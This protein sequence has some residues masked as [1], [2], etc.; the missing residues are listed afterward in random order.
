MMKMKK[1]LTTLLIT[2][3]SFAAVAQQFN[4]ISFL[5]IPVEGSKSEVER[6]LKT[7]KGFYYEDADW[8]KVGI[9]TGNFN[10]YKVNVSIVEY[11]GSVERV[12]V[13][14]PDVSETQVKIQYNN[15]FHQLSKNEKYMYQVLDC[16]GELGEEED[17]SY[18]ISVNSKQ[19][20]NVFMYPPW[21]TLNEMKR[22]ISEYEKPEDAI[23]EKDVKDF[24][25]ATFTDGEPDETKLFLWVMQHSEGNVWF[26]ISTGVRYG[27]YHILLF[28]ENNKNKSH[29][30]D[31]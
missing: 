5:G 23:N 29:E 24:V 10:G 6:R 27:T 15:L 30:D 28:Y 31:L 25:D 1:I 21:G 8:E 12:M 22:K 4:T 11:N 18:E 20:Q 9:L 3:M 16:S 14:Y 17:I 13:A 7:E 2:L 19:Y 26:T